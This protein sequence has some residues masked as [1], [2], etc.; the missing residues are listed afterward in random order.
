MPPTAHS[1]DPHRTA[2]QP[3]SE[4]D[5]TAYPVQSTFP[6]LL[7]TISQILKES[8][9]LPPFD[10]C[11]L[12]HEEQHT[13]KQTDERR[14]CET[15]RRDGSKTDAQGRVKDRT[16]SK[17]RKKKTRTHII[18]S[19]GLFFLHLSFHSASSSL[20]AVSIFSPPT[21]PARHRRRPLQQWKSQMR[22]NQGG[23]FKR[24]NTETTS[25]MRKD[26]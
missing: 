8:P 17:E 24:R 22:A 4:S 2:P 26:K 12:S 1:N 5:P 11:H 14:R 10:S 9:C 21:S 25:R 19:V 6:S 18:V 7:P 15:N 20:P 3:S 13:Y 23:K 16:K